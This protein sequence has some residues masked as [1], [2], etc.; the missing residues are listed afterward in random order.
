MGWASELK[1]IR[2]VCHMHRV[3]D[4]PLTM[5]FS[6]G[7]RWLHQ[8]RSCPVRH[9]GCRRLDYRRRVSR[10]K[11]TDG[12]TLSSVT[13]E[14]HTAGFTLSS[15]TQD[16]DCWFYTA[17]FYM[18]LRRFHLNHS[19]SRGMK[20]VCFYIAICYDVCMDKVVSLHYR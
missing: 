13:Q 3:E 15:V 10:G 17:V 16:K 7:K 4:I 18:G 19:L 6:S 14:K 2:C 5:S 9:M 8:P 1:G 20:T 11:K 12:F